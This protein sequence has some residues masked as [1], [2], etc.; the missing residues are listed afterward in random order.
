MN[1]GPALAL[2]ADVDLFL[3]VRNALDHRFS[4][5]PEVQ[6]HVDHGV[7]TL[8]GTVQWPFQSSEAESA[9]RHLRGVRCLINEIEVE[10]GAPSGAAV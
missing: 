5:P 3:D 10:Y 1:R 8:T 2:P 7:V 9:V 6:P 4:V